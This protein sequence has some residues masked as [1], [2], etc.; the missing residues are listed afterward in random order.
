MFEQYHWA[1]YIVQ[2]I[3][4]TIKYSFTSVS[5]GLMIG[6]LLSVCRLSGNIFLKSFAGIYVSLIRGTPVLLQLSIVYYALPGIIGYNIT[7]FVAGV[8]AFSLNSAAYIAEIIRA[9]ILSV[10]RGQFEAAKVLKI[11]YHLMMRDIILP[12]ALR[13]VLPALVNEM[14][15]MIKESAMIAIIGEADLM[16]RAQIVAAEQ[17]TYF[18]PLLVSGVCYYILVSMLT[19][20]AKI[21]E[22]ILRAKY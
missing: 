11:P 20:F 9:G 1:F 4:L 22:N 2:G 14:A 8:V 7:P 10:D 21:L 6:A 5:C 18:A 15:V 19:Y 12:Q 13:N 3:G 17:Y 16:R